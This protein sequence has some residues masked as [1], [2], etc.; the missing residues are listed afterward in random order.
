MTIRRKEL[1]AAGGDESSDAGIEEDPIVVIPDPF[2][3]QVTSRFAGAISSAPATKAPVS[4]STLL[5]HRA[6]A[7]TGGKS[8]E[9]QTTTKPTVVK[10]T[11]TPPKAPVTA[12]ASMAL[13]DQRVEIKSK[14][15]ATVKPSLPST[16]RPESLLNSED[17]EARKPKLIKVNVVNSKAIGWCLFMSLKF[18]NKF[19][20]RTIS[21]TAQPM[22]M[23]HANY[24]TQIVELNRNVRD[25]NE[26][27]VDKL[28]KLES[29]EKTRVAQTAEI[30]KLQATNKELS[31]DLALQ[32]QTNQLIQIELTKFTQKCGAFA[33]EKAALQE[34]LEKAVVPDMSTQVWVD[35]H[36]L[37]TVLFNLNFY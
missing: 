31:N 37:D 34:K 10:S 1:R 15:K 21:W 17:D 9:V 30:A 6:T 12:A 26:S 28:K 8:I 32:K 11:T 24:E 18:C 29:A 19:M 27:V 16:D 3:N 2:T 35:W 25:L 20:L 13:V 4:T 36:F 23:L 33:K 14:P 5:H 7:A 22:D